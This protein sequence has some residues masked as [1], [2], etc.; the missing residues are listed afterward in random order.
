MKLPRKREIQFFSQV[1]KTATCW[2]WE[3]KLTGSGYPSFGAFGIPTGHRVSYLHHKGEVPFGWEIDH[4]CSNP[5]CVNPAH[6]EA[7]PHEVN[8][9]RK[10]V[11]NRWRGWPTHCKA[12]HVMDD[13]N[14]FWRSNGTGRQCRVCLRARQS[15]HAVRIGE[16][17]FKMGNRPNGTLKHK[18]LYLLTAEDYERAAI[19]EDFLEIF[20]SSDTRRPYG[21]RDTTAKT[22]A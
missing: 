22:A 3:G 13:T 10:K 8:Q 15:E 11:R 20:W 19:T 14:T 2:L 17:P 6:L 4:L 18:H 12:G 21:S 16:N 9:A 7:V 5:A 1:R